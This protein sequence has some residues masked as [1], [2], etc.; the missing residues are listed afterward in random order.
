MLKVMRLRRMPPEDLLLSQ[1]RCPG[2]SRKGDLFGVLP[3]LPRRAGKTLGSLA[4]KPYCRRFSLRLRRILPEDLRLITG[5]LPPNP[6][7]MDCLGSVLT[8]QFQDSISGRW[9]CSI[10]ATRAAEGSRARSAVM[11]R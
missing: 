5:T 7:E 3:H 11:I 9:R 6:L 10:K 2:R 8:T 4:P 1:G